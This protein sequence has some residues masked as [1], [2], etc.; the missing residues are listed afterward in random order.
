MPDVITVPDVTIPDVAMPEA[1]ITMPAQE[2]RVTLPE[3][4]A[5]EELDDFLQQANEHDRNMRG[6]YLLA[7]AALK[8]GPHLKNRDDQTSPTGG[9]GER[10]ED[11]QQE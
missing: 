4:D 3:D 9:N 6:I 8:Y 2:S 11:E 7:Y 1:S 5:I 10:F